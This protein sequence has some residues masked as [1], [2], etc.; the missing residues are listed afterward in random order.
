MPSETRTIFFEQDEL[1]DAANAYRDAAERPLSRGKLTE[2]RA[3][4]AAFDRIVLRY[5]TDAG[6]AEVALSYAQMTELLIRRCKELGIPLPRLGRK[7]IIPADD[8]M[9]LVVR[10][11]DK[12]GV[13]FER[14]MAR[15][16]G[17]ARLGAPMAPA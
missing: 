8:G 11:S 7:H 14:E 9:A 17:L 10:L 5:I 4:P 3:E 13:A 15:L 1:I 6:N 12:S 16:E 2:V